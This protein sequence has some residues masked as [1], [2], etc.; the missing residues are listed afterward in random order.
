MKDDIN[1]SQAKMRLNKKPRKANRITTYMKTVDNVL[2]GG[3]P[4]GLTILWGQAGSGKSLFA[5]S[6]T[7]KFVENKKKVLYFFGEDSFDSPDPIPPYLNNV[8]LVAWKPGA[9]KAVRTII[10]FIEQ[11]KPDLVV[12]DS[13]TTILGVTAKAVPEADIREYT[14]VL[15]S[16]LSGIVPTIGISEIRG[17]YQQTPAGGWGISHAGLQCLKFDKHVID[18][19]WLA[20]DYGADFGQMVWSVLVEKDRDGVARQGCMF[21]AVY[22]GEECFLEEM[23]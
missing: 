23:A 20:Q 10:K 14:G 4:E 15:A 7:K 18:S 21:R 16:K 19:K 1:W 22:V 13:L 12:L 6:I 2:G 3:L 5:K 11:M 8:D 9:S 17:S